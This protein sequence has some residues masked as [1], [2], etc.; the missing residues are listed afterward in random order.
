MIVKKQISGQTQL[1]AQLKQQKQIV[2]PRLALQDINRK[3]SDGECPSSITKADCSKPKDTATMIQKPKNL[4]MLSSKR[5]SAGEIIE[6]AKTLQLGYDQELDLLSAKFQ[7]QQQLI[8]AI[9]CALG[10]ENLNENDIIST[11]EGLKGLKTRQE[12]DRERL[13]M[14]VEDLTS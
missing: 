11:I 12:K 4:K 10:N 1:Q 6:F 8:Q 13:E 9:K 3:V 5:D 14:I 2:I 7:K